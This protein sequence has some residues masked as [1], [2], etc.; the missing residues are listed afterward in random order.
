MTDGW[1]VFYRKTN[2]Y[3]I[4]GAISEAR[5]RE[6]DDT[7]HDIPRIIHQTFPTNALI[8]RAKKLRQTWRDHHPDWIL[9]L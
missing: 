3:S 4:A 9:R 8:D 2:T 7:Q 6:M 1:F 5:E